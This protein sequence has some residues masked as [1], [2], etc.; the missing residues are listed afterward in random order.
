MIIFATR[1]A[2]M[3][4]HTTAVWDTKVEQKYNKLSAKQGYQQNNIHLNSTE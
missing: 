3:K 4:D 1:S 2:G